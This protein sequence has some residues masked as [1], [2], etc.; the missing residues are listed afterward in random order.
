MICYVA[1]RAVKVNQGLGRFLEVEGAL[2]SPVKGEGPVAGK[3]ESSA[4]VTVAI[5]NKGQRMGEAQT[6][7]ERE[8]R[9]GPV[10]QDQA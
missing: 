3:G 4:H 7:S 10:R 9:E 2:K 8:D 6:E 5:A 1:Q